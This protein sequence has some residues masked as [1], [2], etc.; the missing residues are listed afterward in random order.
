[1]PPAHQSATTLRTSATRVTDHPTPAASSPTAAS[2]VKRPQQ[3]T[4]NIKPSP[5]HHP[6]ASGFYVQVG[7]FS[8]ENRAKA[9]MRQLR[10]KGVASIQVVEKSPGL[11]AVLIGP[12]STRRQAEARQQHLLHAFRLKGYPILFG[13]H[14]E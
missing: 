12:F 11:Y 8:D 10:A 7:A 14:H 2:T 5:K 1:M 9:L 3:P 13:A 6:A 4:A